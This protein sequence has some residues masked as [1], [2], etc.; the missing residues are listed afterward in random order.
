MASIP[1]SVDLLV[2][3]GG[4]NGAGIAREAAGRGL[5]VLLVE[6][7]DLAAHTSSASTKLIH[8]GLRYLEHRAFRLVREALAEREVLLRMAPHIVWP[9]EFVLPRDEGLRPAWLLRAGLFLYDH[10]GG[11]ALLPRSRAVNLRQPPHDRILQDRLRQGFAY[12]D[13]WVEDARLVAL[14][15]LDARERGAR[16]MTR[17]RCLGLTRDGRGWTAQVR[18]LGDEPFAVTARAVVNAAGPWVDTVLREAL[19]DRPRPRLRLVK[20]SHLVVPRLWTEPH[21]YI[22]QNRDGRIVFAIP[23]EHDFTLLGTTDVAFT[24]D[25]AAV[26]CSP[27]EAAYICSA[28]SEYLRVP[29]APADAVFAYA[30]VRPL[31]EDEAAS[32]AAVTRDYLLHLDTGVDGAQPPILSVFGGKITTFRRLAMQALD[33]LCA[34]GLSGMRAWNSDAPLPGGEGIDPLG[35]EEFVAAC[36][37]RWLWF[38]PAGTR[39]LARAYGARIER[40]LGGANGL[41]D[42][43]EHFGG[44]FYAAEAHHLLRDEFAVTAQDMLWRRSKLGLHL[45]DG[46]VEA[47]GRWLAAHQT[48]DLHGESMGPLHR[49]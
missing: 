17:T 1:D 31:V 27:E 9:L 21:C 34:A 42:L 13:C 19:P 18:S 30:G 28:V 39:R 6:Q 24:G 37:R 43:G 36:Q 25:P 10:L 16:I 15:A 45:E 5:S 41:E 4:I 29:V 44:D 38:P 11:R 12:A 20:G 35:F 23:Y 22:F 48:G 32:D 7:D 26:S 46:A 8:G 49:G 3:G 2:V 47:L 40:V 33:R 14:S